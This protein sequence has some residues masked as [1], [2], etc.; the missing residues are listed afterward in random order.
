MSRQRPQPPLPSPIE[1]AALFLIDQPGAL[2]RVREHHTPLDNGDC[3]GCGVYRP[4]TWPCVLIYIAR[5]A[6]ELSGER[7]IG[8]AG[9]TACAEPAEVRPVAPRERSRRPGEAGSSAQVAA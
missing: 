9:C 3:A 7:A 1:A 6:D 5:R 2:A 8:T 4:V